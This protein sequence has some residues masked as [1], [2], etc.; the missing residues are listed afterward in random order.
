MK[1]ISFPRLSIYCT[2]PEHPIA[3][4]YRYAMEV[5]GFGLVLLAQEESQAHP[6]R[7]R[8]SLGLSVACAHAC[9]LG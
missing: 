3:F 4:I 7:S 6:S 2:K 8:L 1:S 9:V 5:M